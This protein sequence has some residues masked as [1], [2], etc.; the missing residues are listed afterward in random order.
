MVTSSMDVLD[1]L[2][3]QLK[4][5]DA[6]LLREMVG[7]FVQTVMGA[8]ADA[9]CGAAYGERSRERSNSRNGYRTRDWD[10][11]VGSLDLAIPKLRQGSYFPDWLLQP[12]RRAERALVAVV[13]EAYL[14]GVS[15]RRVEGLVQTLGIERMSKSQV[16][17]L[18]KSLD[19][20]VAAFRNRPLDGAPYTYVWLDALTQRCRE[21]G[22][23]VNVVTVIATA[24][25]A[26]GHREILGVDVC[27]SE[28]GAGWTAFLRGLV[29][30]GLTGVR[31]VISDAHEAS[32]ARSRPSC[33]ARPGNGVAPISS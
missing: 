5:A 23:I 7:S 25:N 3:K 10:T 24:V 19:E 33:P 9:L 22:R 18:A 13:A 31:L 27:T 14:A 26:D 6:D 11:R 8:E 21:A 2:R 32:K 28:D 15:T 16:S 4:Q 17:E 29:A 1:W 20:L 30:R 12:R